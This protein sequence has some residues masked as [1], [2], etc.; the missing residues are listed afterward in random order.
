[1]SV[2]LLWWRLWG[3]YWDFELLWSSM[4]GDEA[5]DLIIRGGQLLNEQRPTDDGGAGL[6]TVVGSGYGLATH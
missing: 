3:S 5:I 1:M 6:D 2:P 4:L